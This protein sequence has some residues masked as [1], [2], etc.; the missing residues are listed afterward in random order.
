MAEALTPHALGERAQRETGRDDLGE[1]GWEVGL[2][3]LLD[4]ATR[5]ADLNEV[6]VGILCGWIHR[7]L[8]NRLQV[9]DWV[10]SHPAIRDEQI[11][12]P[13]VVLGMTRT[14]TTILC[15]LL[16]QDPANRP[17]MKWEG[18]SCCPPPEAASFRSDPRIADPYVHLLPVFPAGGASAFREVLEAV[19]TYEFDRDSL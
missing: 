9:I 19:L 10:N 3:V 4:S 15:E 13:L 11:R 5:A 7:R 12:S 6:G 18:L 2:E 17:L 14:G 16:A 8:V 1:P